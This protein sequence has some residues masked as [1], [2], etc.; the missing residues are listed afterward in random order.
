V[1]SLQFVFFV[2]G[3]KPASLSLVFSSRSRLYP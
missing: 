3:T 1:V 2:P